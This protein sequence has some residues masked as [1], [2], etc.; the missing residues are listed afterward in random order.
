MLEI[1]WRYFPG[2]ENAIRDAHWIKRRKSRYDKLLMIANRAEIELASPLLL[3]LRVMNGML[4]R[5]IEAT[6]TDVI[7]RLEPSDGETS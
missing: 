1:G 2:I 4:P 3:A 6:G 7:G 5:H